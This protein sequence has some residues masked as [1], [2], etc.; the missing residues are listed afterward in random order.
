MFCFP[1][2]KIPKDLP[3]NILSSPCQYVLI[4]AVPLV[5]SPFLLLADPALPQ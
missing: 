1:L 4:A 5:N 3:P 2:I